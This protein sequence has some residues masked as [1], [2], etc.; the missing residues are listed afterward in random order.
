MIL[1]FFRSDF[2]QGEMI[3]TINP[4][5]KLNGSIFGQT[6]DGEPTGP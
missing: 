1:A 5:R 6:E 4:P 3:V 2:S